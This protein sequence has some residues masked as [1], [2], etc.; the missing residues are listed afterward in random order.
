MKVKY[1]INDLGSSLRS[2]FDQQSSVGGGACNTLKALVCHHPK[3]IT[4]IRSLEAEFGQL[5]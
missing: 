5:L 4:K 1:L 3:D 2:V